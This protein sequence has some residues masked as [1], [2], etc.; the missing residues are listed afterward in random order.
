MAATR[1]AGGGRETLAE[2]IMA[3]VEK[4][5]DGCWL[6]TGATVGNER[7][8]YG[9]IMNEGKVV[10]VRRALYGLLN[11]GRP[12]RDREA[13]STCGRPLCVKPSHLVRRPRRKGGQR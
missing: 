3:K 4:T 11:P 12:L 5:P 7:R 9:V 6:W 2:R 1:Q 13:G 8:R 10:N